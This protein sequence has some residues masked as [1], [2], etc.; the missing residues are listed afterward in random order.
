MYIFFQ[1]WEFYCFLWVTGIWVSSNFFGFVQRQ[2]LIQGF[3]S[4]I[5]KVFQ[6]GVVFSLNVCILRKFREVYFVQ[7]LFFLVIFKFFSVKNRGVRVERRSLGRSYFL[8]FQGMWLF[9]GE[10]SF[11]SFYQVSD[12]LVFFLYF[13]FFQNKVEIWIWLG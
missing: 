2:V 3:F 6:E 12:F 9:Y 10:F 1:V 8:K 11:Y 13:Y 5:F 4:F 7:V